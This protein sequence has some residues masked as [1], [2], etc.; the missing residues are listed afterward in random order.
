M[1]GRRDA[2]SSLQACSGQRPS[3]TANGGDFKARAGGG[4]Q[5]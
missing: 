5:G 2:Q 3:L 4:Q 1:R